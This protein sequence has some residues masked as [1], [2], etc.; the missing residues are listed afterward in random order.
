MD[1]VDTFQERLQFIRGFKLPFCKPTVYAKSSSSAERRDSTRL[2][3]TTVTDRGIPRELKVYRNDE[4]PGLEPIRSAL[5]NFLFSSHFPE[6]IF[7]P[8]GPLDHLR[9]RA[10]DDAETIPPSGE[11][12]VSHWLKTALFDPLNET[13]ASTSPGEARSWKVIGIGK[14]G[15]TEWALFMNGV[16][17]VILKLKPHIVSRAPSPCFW[18]HI[19]L[20]PKQV[21]SAL[22]WA[23][24][25]CPAKT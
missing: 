18:P 23:R 19:L 8:D 4:L 6:A 11:T 17:V 7:R 3:P 14:T 20:L 21:N 16:M 13:F 25:F 12:G 15:K 1:A 5:E 22:R 10:R 9:G 2:D 24:S